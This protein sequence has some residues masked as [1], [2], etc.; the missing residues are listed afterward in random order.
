VREKIKI[1]S[2]SKLIFLKKETNKHNEEG[3]EVAVII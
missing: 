3:I 2:K 1:T